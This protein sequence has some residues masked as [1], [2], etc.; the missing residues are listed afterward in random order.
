MS[1]VPTERKRDDHGNLSCS[2]CG[3][4]QKE[5]KKLIAGPDGLHLRRVHR[6]LQRHH[7]GGDREGVRE[8]RP[9]AGPQAGRDQDGPRRVRDRPGAREEDPR[10]RGPQPL[11]A[12]RRQASAPTTSSSQ[13]SN[14]LLLGPT[15]SGKTLLAQTLASILNVPFAIADATT[16]TEAGYVGEDVENII[17][18][19]L[20]NADHDIEKA[21]RGIVYI[22]EI[23]KIARKGD[24]PVDHPRRV[25]RGRAA[26]AAQDHRR[27]GRATCRP[28]AAASTRSRSSCRSTR[29]TSCSSA[30]AR[31][32][33]SRTSSSSAS[34]RSR[35]ASAPRSQSKNERTRVGAAA[36][37]CSPRT[38]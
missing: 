4:S 17:V 8:L 30:A 20:Q 21:Q 11:Q 2:F 33:G 1:R 6:A 16:L 28:R 37:R 24:N 22:D 9:R 34:A 5:V 3:K 38:C 15:G 35:S 19:L 13:K 29:P 25:G 12:H 23:D 7:R 27:H 18:K 32:S 31:S 14:I 26:G 36:A 10:G